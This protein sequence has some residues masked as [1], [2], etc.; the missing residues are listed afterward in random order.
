MTPRGSGN[1]DLPTLKTGVHRIASN[2]DSGPWPRMA[3]SL[4]RPKSPK[5]NGRGSNMPARKRRRPLTQSNSATIPCARASAIR[6]RETR[7][8]GAPVK[9]ARR[10]SGHNPRPCSL[11]ADL[12][13]PDGHALGFRIED[14]FGVALFE[15][16]DDPR[17]LV[18]ERQFLFTVIGAFA[19]DK[20]F[21]DGVQ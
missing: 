5:S 19:Q 6:T 1:T 10:L 16:S 14:D 7:I 3:P 12:P 8:T 15:L 18:L 11:P 17:H 4:H 20:G 13:D 2:K 9:A 21:D